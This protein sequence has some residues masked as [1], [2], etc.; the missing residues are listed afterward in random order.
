MIDAPSDG[1]RITSLS[2]NGTHLSNTTQVN[3]I[4]ADVFVHDS[5]ASGINIVD[6]DNTVTD[7]VIERAWIASSGQ[8]GIDLDNAAGWQIRNNHIYGVQLNAINAHRCFNTGIHD[9]Y[10][11]NFGSQATSTSTYYGIR[12]TVQGDVAN[13][14]AGNMVN[15]MFGLPATGSFVYIGLDGV[16]YGTGRVT[17]TGNGIVGRSTNPEIGLK[18]AKGGGTALNVV[19]TGNLVDRLITQVS[20]SGATVTA[21]Y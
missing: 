15:Q 2:S 18:Y 11:E 8:H 21:G 7:W 1:I 20:N 5:G 16:N 9:N 10:I 6:P 4:I 14:I 13:T 12:C 17:V 3:S 19:S